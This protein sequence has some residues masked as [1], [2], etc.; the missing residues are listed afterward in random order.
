ME[1]IQIEMVL[2]MYCLQYLHQYPCTPVVVRD[3]APPAGAATPPLPRLMAWLGLVQAQV[4]WMSSLLSAA[5]H[6]E[7]AA[8]Q[9]RLQDTQV[10]IFSS[11]AVYYQF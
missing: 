4:Y 3:G 9:G 10:S 11:Y 2:C 7:G 5:G 6:L 1:W 8:V